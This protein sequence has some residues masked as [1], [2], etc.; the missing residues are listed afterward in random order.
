MSDLFAPIPSF[1]TVPP[2]AAPA[3]AP[4]DAP[5]VAPTA[6]PLNVQTTIESV[7]LGSLPINP[8]RTI[9]FLNTENWFALGQ[10]VMLLPAMRDGM[11][12]MQSIEDGAE[13]FLLAD[14]FLIAPDFQVDLPDAVVTALAVTDSSDIMVLAIVSLP[15]TAGTSATVNLA[16]PLIFSARARSGCQLNA[17]AETDPAAF[18]PFDFDRFVQPTAPDAA[19]PAARVA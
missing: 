19:T 10:E 14:P 5:M 16:S 9:R 18:T 13:T 3:V 4:F 11:F 6:S 7:L 1:P 12:W 2:V 8:D 15:T 17:S